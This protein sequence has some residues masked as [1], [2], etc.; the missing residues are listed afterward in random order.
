[1]TP[2]I[3]LVEDNA[4]DAELALL[5]FRQHG[6]ADRLR[7]ARSIAEAV[8]AIEASLPKL[9]LLDLK[10][11]GESGLELLARLKSEARTRAV[12]VVML[13]TS[14][15]RAD[16][17]EC[18]RLGANSYVTKPVDFDHFINLA[19]QLG[20]YWLVTNEPPERS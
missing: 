8:Q 19:K 2:D 16:I 5:A 15:E 9:I 20:D 3:L 10:L 13:T 6:Y 17:A 14:R 4:A 11:L 18:Y 7:I 12:P 1:V